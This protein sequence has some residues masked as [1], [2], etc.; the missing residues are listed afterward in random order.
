MEKATR[1]NLLLAAAGGVTAAV[2]LTTKSAT[3]V[4]TLQARDAAEAHGHS[5]G[6]ISGPLAE[7]TVS[8][9]QWPADSTVDRMRVANPAN[10]NTHQLIPNEVKIQAGGTV[11]FAVAGFHQIVIYDDGTQAGD[12]NDALAYT[13]PL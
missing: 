5:D 6:P 3:E 12:I 13:A 4:H 11:N 8:F 1:R 10:R 9:G 7:A 2:G